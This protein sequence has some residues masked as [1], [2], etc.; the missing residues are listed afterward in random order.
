MLSLRKVYL[1][2]EHLQYFDDLKATYG[3]VFGVY[4]ILLSIELHFRNKHM[5]LKREA[6]VTGGYVHESAE[7]EPKPEEWKESYWLES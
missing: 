4:P 6:G 5:L 1:Q 2:M 7:P 3:A